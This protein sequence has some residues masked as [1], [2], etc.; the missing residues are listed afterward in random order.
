VT[1]ASEQYTECPRCH[2]QAWRDT[3]LTQQMLKMRQVFVTAW[4]KKVRNL[5]QK[6][7]RDPTTFNKQTS[8]DYERDAI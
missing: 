4:D 8:I 6:D 5:D 3:S 7:N 1:A 2:C